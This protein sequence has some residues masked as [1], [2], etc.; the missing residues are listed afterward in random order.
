MGQAENVSAPQEIG[1][2]IGVMFGSVTRTMYKKWLQT[3][4]AVW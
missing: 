3:F 2:T 1:I 4:R